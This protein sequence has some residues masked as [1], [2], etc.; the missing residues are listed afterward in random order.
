MLFG[1][2]DIFVLDKFN[3][4]NIVR[5]PIESGRLSSSQ[6]CK[7]SSLKLTSFPKEFGRCFNLRCDKSSISNCVNDPI[8]SRRVEI[9]FIDKFNFFNIVRAPIVFG[10]IVKP[11]FDDKFKYTNL[12]KE[13]ISFGRVLSSVYDMFKYL[14]FCNIKRCSDEK[15]KAQ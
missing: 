2:V 9:F 6:F 10:R 13:P 15:F 4:F 5:E 1:R 8:L 3:L 12:A 14:N 7:R 11:S